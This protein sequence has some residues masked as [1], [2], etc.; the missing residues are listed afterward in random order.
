MEMPIDM[1]LAV[2]EELMGLRASKE[3]LGKK[4]ESASAKRT[5]ELSEMEITKIEYEQA[6][7]K[8]K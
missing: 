6:I 2:D 8:G 1:E 4:L 3:G 5:E 7:L